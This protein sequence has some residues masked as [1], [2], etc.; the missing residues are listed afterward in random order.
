MVLHLQSPAVSYAW[1]SDLDLLPFKTLPPNSGRLLSRAIRPP[2]EGVPFASRR[3]GR[4]LPRLA[5]DLR[6][7]PPDP[8]LRRLR[9]RG[10]AQC[11]GAGHYAGRLGREIR[12]GKG[13][14]QGTHVLVSFLQEG[15]NGYAWTWFSNLGCP[16]DI[17]WFFC[18][19]TCP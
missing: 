4:L 17:R 7:D 1:T 14:V 6:K 16:I 5:P 12:R 15:A 13:G 10:P 9:R 11:F 8:G 3:R 2:A 18:R 19:C